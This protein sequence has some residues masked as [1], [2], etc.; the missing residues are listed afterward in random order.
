MA[1]PGAYVCNRSLPGR[2]VRDRSFGACQ[3]LR[4]PYDGYWLNCSGRSLGAR[5]GLFGLSVLFSVLGAVRSVKRS[6]PRSSRMVAR[7]SFHSTGGKKQLRNL[8][9]LHPPSPWPVTYIQ[10]GLRCSKLT[11]AAALRMPVH[12]CSNDIK[13]SCCSSRIG[14]RS[15]HKSD[16]YSTAKGRTR[17]NC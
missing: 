3:R 4:W 13:C 2:C 6:K 16:N 7:I 17:G 14:Q 11:P 12:K 5:Q 15:T 1:L 10:G 9:S 8:P